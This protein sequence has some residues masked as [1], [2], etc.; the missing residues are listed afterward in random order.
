MNDAVTIDDLDALNRRV[1]DL[2]RQFKE[3][4]PHDDFAGHCR[5]H[6]IQIQMLLDRRKLIAAVQE[7]TISALVW[8][9]IV[10]AAL[11]LWAWIKAEVVK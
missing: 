11:A 10:A 5:Y 7:K 1:D 8:S 6:E 4:F 3:A 9:V 2:E